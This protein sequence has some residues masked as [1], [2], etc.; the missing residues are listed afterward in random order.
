MS[1]TF[2]TCSF[3]GKR[4]DHVH[5]LIAGPKV[6][7]CDECVHLCNG[8]LGQDDPGAIGGGTPP[9][10]APGGVH[11]ETRRALRVPKP[12]EIF[13]FLDQYVIGHA[14]TKKVLSVAVH[15]HYK[16]L[17]QETHFGL[18]DPYA[19]VEIEK[20]NIL[21]IGPTGSGKTLLAKTLARFL[22]VPFTITDATTLTEAG[23]VG[24][25]VENILLSLIQAADG[26]IARAQ[27]GIIYVDEIDKIGRKTENVSITRDVSGE[28]VQQALLKILEGTMARVP[29][30]G[31]RK[32]PQQEYIKIDTSHI[33]FICGGAF[34]GLDEIAKRRI[35]TRALGF[36]SDAEAHA[37][38][39]WN[40]GAGIP[41]EP[42]DLVRYG[43]I[44]ELVGRLPV[45]T[46][47]AELTEDDLVRIL[48]E[49][50]NAMVSQYQKLL[51]MEGIDLSFTDAALRELAHVA[52][53]RRTGA[54]GLRSVL[55][56]LMLEVMFEAPRDGRGGTIRVT[57]SMVDKRS[58]AAE[59]VAEALRTARANA[60]A[61]E[62]A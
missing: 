17:R 10:I 36:G 60:N 13:A 20:S 47:L 18:D 56:K 32:H 57:K 9:L 48:V 39:T 19:G 33:L 28:G 7:I 6:N 15:N 25:D 11:T 51:A 41:A 26:D 4:Q 5:K 31:G 50:R 37:R 8:L 3:C 14:H 24:E 58:A 1:R 53:K 62:A 54:R 23:Y 45:T 35:G 61:G 44:P 55:E 38:E 34:V 43:M 12:H 52:L 22:D 46:E 2:K 30:G 40:E 49:P 27:T 21:L 59:A 42:E 29:P 16:R